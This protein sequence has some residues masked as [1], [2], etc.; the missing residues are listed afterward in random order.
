LR[1]V[2]QYL[3]VFRHFRK[4]KYLPIISFQQNI[5]EPTNF[6]IPLGLGYR[7]QGKI[8]R[9]HIRTS[10]GTP[11]STHLTALTSTPHNHTPP[12]SPPSHTHLSNFK[13]W[14]KKKQKSKHRHT[15]PPIHRHIPCLTPLPHR[16]YLRCSAGAGPS[17]SHP[18][19][20]RK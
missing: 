12:S 9:Y 7:R 2:Y 14:N 6:R 13:P 3:E 19:P 18:Y 5:V 15:T 8:F 20:Y 11:I 16:G 1:H 4:K 10:L 17:Y